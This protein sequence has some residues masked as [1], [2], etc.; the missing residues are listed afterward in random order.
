MPISSR[1]GVPQHV[2]PPWKNMLVFR[3]G[4][5]DKNG[6]PHYHDSNRELL[7]TTVGCGPPM[8]ASGRL[9]CAPKI[10]SGCHQPGR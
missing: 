8:L 6:N 3:N 7:A 9:R 2:Y 4:R 1:N 10:S 5:A